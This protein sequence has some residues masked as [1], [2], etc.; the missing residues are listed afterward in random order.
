MN[1]HID[2][3]IYRE[4][5]R[6]LLTYLR[7]SEK[8]HLLNKLN[9]SK[10]LTNHYRKQ[11]QCKAEQKCILIQLEVRSLFVVSCLKQKTLFVQRINLKKKYLY[12]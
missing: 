6:Q 9:K 10:F 8:T 11:S 7:S 2:V 3:G 4:V 12:F 1:R 5:G